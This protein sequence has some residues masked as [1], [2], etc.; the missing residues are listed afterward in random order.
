M[1]T[2]SVVLLLPLLRTSDPREGNWLA[3]A[4]ASAIDRMAGFF[5]VRSSSNPVP[6]VERMGR[7]FAGC[8]NPNRRRAY[9]RARTHRHEPSSLLPLGV[10]FER[11]YFCGS[12]VTIQMG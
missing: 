7:E 10:V 1:G 6:G 12:L 4:E 11:V 9:E 5:S 3:G 2:Y 8:S